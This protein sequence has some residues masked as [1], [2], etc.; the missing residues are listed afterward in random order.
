MEAIRARSEPGVGRS[1]TRLVVRIR[2]A[3]G[4]LLACASTVGAACKAE[5]RADAAVHRSDSAGVAV[6]LTRDAPSTWA[7][8]EGDPVLS[9]GGAD[10]EGPTQFSDVRGVLVDTRGNLWVA[11]GASGELRL[12]RADGSAWKTVGGRGDG[13]G[14][15][16]R[17]RLLGTFRGDSVAVWD[18]ANPRLSVFDSTGALARTRNP[19]PTDEVP[20]QALGVFP[21][22]TLLAR[23]PRVYMAR[24]L[25]PG[26]VLS[27]SASLLRID[28]VTSVRDTLV[29]VGGMRWL[30]TGRSQIPVPF[31]ANPAFAL[32]GERLHVAA[33]PGFRVRTFE[34]GG[35]REIRGVDRPEIE[36]GPDHVERYERFVRAAVRDSVLAAEYLSALASR[37]R[38]DRLP[39]WNRLVVGADGDQWLQRYS[40]DPLEA[41]TWDVFEPGGVWLGQVEA[42]AG[43]LLHAVVAGRLVGVWRDALGVEHVR[44]YGLR[45]KA[46]GGAPPPPGS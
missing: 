16:R 19:P 4:P 30:W 34:V 15:F 41:R 23:V 39:A 40:P 2:S 14:E 22:G 37:E 35:L 45:P 18:D 11:D 29:Q 21:D 8:V 25:E 26:T 24:D 13:P 10:V 28:L 42:P 17:P 9:L 38:P 31:V 5:P 36:V 3:L 44:A 1:P 20:P 43:F 33:G 12:F 32:E 6:T 46:P 27:D 7:E